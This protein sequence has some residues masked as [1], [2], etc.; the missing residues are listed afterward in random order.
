MLKNFKIWKKDLPHF[1][2]IFKDGPP[3]VICQPRVDVSK[4]APMRP[5][6]FPW[7]PLRPNLKSLLCSV[8]AVGGGGLK[9]G[10]TFS[11]WKILVCRPLTDSDIILKNRYLRL[12][13][14]IRPKIWHLNWCMSILNGK[15]N[16]MLWSDISI[17][18]SMF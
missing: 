12:D 2:H 8:W 18:F 3:T 1:Y 10:V 14:I 9:S 17:L 5:N 11:I 13:L 6:N 7:G 16:K 4:I 15:E